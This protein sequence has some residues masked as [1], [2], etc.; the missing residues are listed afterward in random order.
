VRTALKR[1]AKAGARRIVPPPDRLG[2]RVILCYHSV[3]PADGYLSLSPELFEAHLEWL[4]SHC[5]V[6]ALSDLV[7]DRGRAAE[8]RV[9]IT[10]DDG[11]ADNHAHAL[12][13][14]ARRGLTATFFLT[15]GFLERD[16]AVMA[17][18]A[19]T[20]HTPVDQLAPLSWGQVEEMRAA[21]MS[22]G[23]HTWGHRNLAR[24]E[25]AEVQRELTRSREVL[26]ARLA[27]PVPAIAYPWGKLRRHVTERTFATAAGT[28]YRLGVFSL[29]R[30]VR[31]SDPPL[32]IPRFGVGAEPVA[33]VAGKVGGA[34]D[35]HAAVH[36]RMP[37]LLA[38]ALWPEQA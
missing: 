36:E 11:Y 12:P 4:Q 9:A 5:T 28:G 27:A 24:I 3:N 6:M 35:W 32:R 18:L 29:P 38:R 10:F 7:A 25:D 15:A 21:G 33:S 34:I 37:A 26:E 14:L 16:D 19:E 13:I 1:A 31:E 22:F 8:P 17:Q 23:S 20:W 2:R 30:P